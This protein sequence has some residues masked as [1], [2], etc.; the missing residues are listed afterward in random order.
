MAVVKTTLRTT[1]PRSHLT[2]VTTAMTPV[3]SYREAQLHDQC[4]VIVL[5]QPGMPR[6]NSSERGARCF[7]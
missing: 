1:R 2:V 5:E 4:T 6:R 7:L 3:E